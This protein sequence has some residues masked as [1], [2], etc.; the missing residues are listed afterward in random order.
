M[1]FHF[2]ECLDL[3]KRQI[4][5]VSQRDDFVERAKQFEGIANNLPLVQALADA[6]GHLGE[7]MKAINVLK[8]VGLA[9][10]DEDD[11]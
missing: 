8:D 1:T 7:K 2:Q 6:R 9:V 10:R 3:R 4:L 5:S 11:V